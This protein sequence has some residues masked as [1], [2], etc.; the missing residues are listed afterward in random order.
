MSEFTDTISAN[1]KRAME[2]LSLLS[3]STFLEPANT[4]ILKLAKLSSCFAK[5]GKDEEISMDEG[6]ARSKVHSFARELNQMSDLDEAYIDT[7]LDVGSSLYLM[8]IHIKVAKYIF[9]N[10]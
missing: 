6:K 1:W 4:K 3:E 10:L 7:A 2:D 5:P 9:N 8:A